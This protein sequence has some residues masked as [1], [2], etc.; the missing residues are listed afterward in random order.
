VWYSYW[1]HQDS[2]GAWWCLLSR[3]FSACLKSDYWNSVLLWVSDLNYNFV[4]IHF[5]SSYDTGFL[6][7]PP[8]PLYLNEVWQMLH[9]Y[10]PIGRY[11]VFEPLF[12]ALNYLLFWNSSRIVSTLKLW[13]LVFFKINHLSIIVLYLNNDNFRICSWISVFI[14]FNDAMMEAP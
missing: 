14:L 11:H 13:L 8:I 4:N 10:A 7:F 3:N 1:D 12:S 5:V 2:E 6:K 9:K